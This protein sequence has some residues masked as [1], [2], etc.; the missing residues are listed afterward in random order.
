MSRDVTHNEVVIEWAKIS[1]S[2]QSFLFAWP[3]IGK[4][5]NGACIY[6]SKSYNSHAASSVTLKFYGHLK[7]VFLAPECVY[8]YSVVIAVTFTY[9]ATTAGIASLCI[10][11]HIAKIRQSVSLSSYRA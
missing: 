11:T 2:Q 5:Q 6:D 4:W 3:F 7:F 8:K 9:H 1:M 10:I